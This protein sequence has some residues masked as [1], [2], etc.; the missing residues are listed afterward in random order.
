MRTQFH[1]KITSMYLLDTEFT[2]VF[3]DVLKHSRPSFKKETLAFRAF[4]QYPKLYPFSI[5]KQ[6]L[7]TKMLLSSDTALFLTTI[8]SYK[9]AYSETI[10]CRIK[11]TAL[12]SG[13]NPTLSSLHSCKC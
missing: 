9:G 2:F 10:T 7:D 3:D 1:I 6:H 12:E 13:I 5:L 4:P 8:K 11:N